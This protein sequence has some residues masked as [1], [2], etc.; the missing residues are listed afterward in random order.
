ME[1]VVG[2]LVDIQPDA[3]FEQQGDGRAAA[4]HADGDAEQAGTDPAEQVRRFGKHLDHDPLVGVAIPTL[5][6]LTERRNDKRPFFV[7][8]NQLGLVAQEPVAVEKTDRVAVAHG[9][10]P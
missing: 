5:R 2:R 3:V 8:Q 7:G 10:S 6:R 9:L 4:A 1:Y